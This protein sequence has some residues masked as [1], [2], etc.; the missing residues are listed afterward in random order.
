MQYLPF[1]PSVLQD[2]RPYVVSFLCIAADSS[3][4]ISFI[5][6]SI[7]ACYADYT[8]DWDEA[9]NVSSSSSFLIMLVLGTF[10]LLT[11][12]Y[13]TSNMGMEFVIRPS[14]TASAI[15]VSSNRKGIQDTAH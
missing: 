5:L 8:S 15:T 11:L 13:W 6:Q 12:W 1:T 14:L 4:L 10:A 2:Y 3:H 9:G 7:S